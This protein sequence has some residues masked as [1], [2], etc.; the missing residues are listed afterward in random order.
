WCMKI[1]DER[2]TKQ[3][4]T[5][6]HAP[7]SCRV[8]QVMQDIPQFGQDFMCKRG[9]SKMYPADDDRCKVWVGF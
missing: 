2:L 6:A 5:D 3:L 9:L 1:T 4:M 7:S 8:N